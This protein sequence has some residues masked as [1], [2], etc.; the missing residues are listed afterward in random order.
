MKCVIV[1]LSSCVH[2]REGWYNSQRVLLFDV[3]SKPPFCKECESVLIAGVI[4]KS[5]EGPNSIEIKCVLNGLSYSE[6]A[7][8]CF[9]KAFVMPSY[10]CRG[11]RSG[12]NEW[13]RLQINIYTMHRNTSP[14]WA[15]KVLSHSCAGV[16]FYYSF[17]NIFHLFSSR[18]VCVF[19]ARLLSG[20]TLFWLLFY[21]SYSYVV[22]ISKTVKE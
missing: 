12:K 18:R 9:Q 3:T 21:K 11:E 14:N 19:F 5:R 10:I 22:E 20:H 15:H 17:G 2:Y 7:K 16:D 1:E 6:S 4:Q 8:S 13:I